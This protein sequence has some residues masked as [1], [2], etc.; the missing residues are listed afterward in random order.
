[1]K[2]LVIDDEQDIRLVAE[3]GLRSAGITVVTAESGS[4]GLAAARRERPD[5]I[6]LDVMMPEMDGYDTFA[7]LRSD[8]GLA[9]IPVVFLTAKDPDGRD[10]QRRTKGAAGHIAK[11]FLPFDLAAALRRILGQ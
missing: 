3:I 1:M 7:A 4:A 8:P 11:P 2:V 6:L 9:A 10:A 5:A